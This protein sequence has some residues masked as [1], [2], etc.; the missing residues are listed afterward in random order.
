MQLLYSLFLGADE[1]WWIKHLCAIA[2]D[3]HPKVVLWANGIAFILI[4]VIQT[5]TNI[6]NLVQRGS[7]MDCCV[8]NAYRCVALFGDE[9]LLLLI[10]P[11]LQRLSIAL[12]SLTLTVSLLFVLIHRPF[13]PK[14][15]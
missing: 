1:L 2:N 4:S 5:F 3:K 14:D 10:L 8:Y 15:E 7:R 13:L 6:I 12:Y 11:N 9:A